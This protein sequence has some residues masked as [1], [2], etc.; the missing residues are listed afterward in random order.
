MFP[1]DVVFQRLAYVDD[2]ILAGPVNEKNVEATLD[3]IVFLD[4]DI[5]LTE[6]LTFHDSVSI[7]IFLV[8]FILR[9]L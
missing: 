2:L 4:E 6:P 3:R 9:I 5:V 7:F 8:I 1:D